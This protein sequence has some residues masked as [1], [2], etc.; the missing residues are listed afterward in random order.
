MTA[1]QDIRQDRRAS[2]RRPARRGFAPVEPAFD[3]LRPAGRRQGRAFTLVELLVVIL[4]IMVL[5]GISWPTI[6]KIQ[7]HIRS[8]SS[9]AIVN[10]IHGACQQYQQEL[11]EYPL[12]VANLVQELTGYQ[13]LGDWNPK[14]SKF[15]LG[16]GL[17]GYG[18]RL[19]P[20][21]RKYGPYGGTENLHWAKRDGLEAVF[22]DA[23][24]GPV[25]YSRYTGG[26]PP[27][28]QLD[29]CGGPDG[30]PAPQPVVIMEKYLQNVDGKFFRMDFA[31]ISRGPDGKWQPYCSEDPA[32]KRRWTPSDD[33]TNLLNE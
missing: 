14:T 30:P 17:D 29:K 24:N 5:V 19:V 7:I 23:F 28:Q 12:D 1:D 18:M 8:N 11:G 16:D 6:G 26:T 9:Q 10:V 27:W 3:R 13:V 32:G 2:A 21:G 4:I 31:V 20:R 15:E 25:L 22:L 33:I